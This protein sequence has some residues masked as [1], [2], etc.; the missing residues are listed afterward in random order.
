MFSTT[1]TNVIGFFEEKGKKMLT[2]SCAIEKIAYEESDGNTN[3]DA[4]RKSDE[5]PPTAEPKN[6]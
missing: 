3:T 4:C 5:I 2:R 6:I 1:D